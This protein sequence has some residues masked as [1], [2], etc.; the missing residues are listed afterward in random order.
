MVARRLGRASNNGEIYDGACACSCHAFKW[1]FVSFC[2]T[3]PCG[4]GHRR[5]CWAVILALVAC[6]VWCGVVCAVP[7]RAVPCR[8]VLCCAVLCCAVL[9]CVLRYAAVWCGMHA[10]AT[11]ESTATTSRAALAPSLGPTGMCTPS[12]P[13]ICF[14]FR[15]HSHA[16]HFVHLFVHF[17]G[18]FIMCVL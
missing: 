4:R 5:H 13:P 3:T 14:L 6:C 11:Q 10:C 17:F 8:A 15:S 18:S 1:Y 2:P 12:S 9:C 7:C 16:Q